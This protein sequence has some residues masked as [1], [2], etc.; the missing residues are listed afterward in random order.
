MASAHDVAKYI[1]EHQGSISTWKL[2]KLVYYTQAWHLVWAEKPLFQDRIEAWANGPVV[3]ALYN[4]HRGQF[5]VSK[6]R[7]GDTDKLTE[8]EEKTIDAVLSSYGGL[9]GHQLVFLTHNEGP[10]IDAR[11]GVAS[12]ERSRNQISTESMAA[13]YLA[14]AADDDATPIGEIDWESLS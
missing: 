8:R 4:R 7:K 13:F 1:L 5:S 2:Q 6:W 11:E 14:V 3:P 10:W 12:T 9:S